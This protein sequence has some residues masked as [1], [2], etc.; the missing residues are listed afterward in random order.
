MYGDGER[1]GAPVGADLDAEIHRFLA[2]E[3]AMLDRHAYAD[4]FE[5]VTDDISYRITVQVVHARE[6][7]PVEHAIV[8]E[9]HDSLRLRVDQLADPRL[10]RAENP[11]S[12]YRRFVAN[13]RADVTEDPDS[14]HVTESLLVYRNR[15]P[16]GV[17][18]LF[19]GEREDVLR[20]V[21]GRLRIA[22]RIVR[23]DQSVLG[24]TLST[25]L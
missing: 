17:P 10:T 13:V 1:R 23:L 4:W 11:P 2:D 19:A 25:L 20:R 21:D 9:T 6:D 12:S 5:L 8:D 15:Q 7:G 3:A 24:T 16:N 22:S 18:E 14:F